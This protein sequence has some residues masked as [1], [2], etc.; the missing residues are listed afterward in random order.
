M[1]ENKV[2]ELFQQV[3]PSRDPQCRTCVT[4]NFIYLEGGG[5][6]HI[7]LCGR[8]SVQIHQRQ[9]RGLDMGALKSRL[10]QFGPVRANEFLLKCTIA[11]YE[12]T[13]FP[14]GRAIVKGTDDPAVARGIYAKYIGA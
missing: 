1:L 7:T 13:V 9:P 4:R 6:T 12:L 5:P 11:P 3:K 8:N 14:D 2:N 10:E